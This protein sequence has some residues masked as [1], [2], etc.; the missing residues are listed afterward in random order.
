VNIPLA[1]PLPEYAAVERAVKLT[2]V[3]RNSFL[4]ESALQRAREILIEHGELEEHDIDAFAD[5]ALPAARSA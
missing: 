4:I 5:D 3:S 2:G 1:M